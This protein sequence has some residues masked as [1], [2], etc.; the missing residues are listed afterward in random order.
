[1]RALLGQL[2]LDAG[3]PPAAAVLFAYPMSASLVPRGTAAWSRVV[4][5]TH[6]IGVVDRGWLATA[7]DA[8]GRA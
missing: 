3:P 5:D 8:A 6:C 7:L 4:D 2:A 1:M